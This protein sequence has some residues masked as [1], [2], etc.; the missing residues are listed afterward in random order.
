MILCFIII[1][2]IIFNENNY[3]KIENPFN[4]RIKNF[5]CIK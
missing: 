3:K 5:N 2:F 1:L 4:R